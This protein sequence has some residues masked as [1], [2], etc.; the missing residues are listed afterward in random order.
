MCQEPD[1]EGGPRTQI[2]LIQ[3]MARTVA[4]KPIDAVASIALAY[5]RASDTPLQGPEKII[6][7]GLKRR[8]KLNRRCASNGT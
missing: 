7:H 2:R 4:F 5:A 3:E 1:R 6:D 8:A